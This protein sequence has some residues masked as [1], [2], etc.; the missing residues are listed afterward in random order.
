MSIEYTYD[1][2]R[3]A[4]QSWAE[5]VEDDFSD[6][7]AGIIA[8][9]ETRLLRDLDLEIFLKRFNQMTDFTASVIPDQ[10]E[11][12]YP[13][14][15]F[16]IESVFV[17]WA[18]EAELNERLRPLV[19]RSWSY[20]TAMFGDLTNEQFGEFRYWADLPRGPATEDGPYDTIDRPRFV[21]APV[22]V[23]YFW[24]DGDLA[25]T[26]WVRPDGLTPDNQETY[27]SKYM[28]DLLFWATAI[29]SQSFLKNSAKVDESANMYAS[30]LPKAIDETADMQRKPY[31]ALGVR[32]P[33]GDQ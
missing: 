5:D 17:N 26:A 23:D 18:P 3:S 1:S 16:K 14:G 7:L 21:I 28:G 33:G 32:K 29:E 4:I 25:V 9:A 11:F 8:K 6:N 30:L 31:K 12:Q 22:T 27:L 13:V 15:A 2:L 20:L 10:R 24:S 19:R